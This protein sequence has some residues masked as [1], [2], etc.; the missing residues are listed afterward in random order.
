MGMTADEKEE[1]GV[2]VTEALDENFTKHEETI[3]KLTNGHAKIVPDQ[4]SQDEEGEESQ[5]DEKDTEN[6]GGEENGDVNEEEPEDD[7][8]PSNLQ[9]AWEMLELAKVIFTRNCEEAKDDASLL[10]EQE[11]KLCETY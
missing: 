2:K 11:G 7:E 4:E 3:A 9:L 10:T 1:V 5:D 8:D 6:D